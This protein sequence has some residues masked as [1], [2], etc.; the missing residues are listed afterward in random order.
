MQLKV[1]VYFSVR[2]LFYDKIYT[3]W[4]KNVLIAGNFIRFLHN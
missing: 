3:N 2:V 4:F 1:R